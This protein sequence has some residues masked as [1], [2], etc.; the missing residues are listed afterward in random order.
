MTVNPQYSKAKLS[1]TD[2]PI[3]HFVCPLTMKEMNGA[4]PFMYPRSCGCV[5]STAGFRALT[6]A[7]PSSDSSDTPKEG[8]VQTEK[9]LCPQCSEK[10]DPTQDVYTIN[11]DIEEEEK[12]FER[13][14]LQPTIKKVKKRKAVDVAEDTPET[15]RQVTST[16]PKMNPHH[17]RSSKKVTE[18][19]AES[20]KK[21]M[22]TM[23][24]AVRSIYQGKGAAAGKTNWISQG[25]FTRVCLFYI[26]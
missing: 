9:K 8:V 19:I 17:S 2:T 10:Y 14:I 20:E 13:M 5:F 7:S 24:D 22:A 3:A 18:G 21:R 1:D 15:K 11:P 26:I 25:T 4:V 23:T 6:A 12:M 16:E